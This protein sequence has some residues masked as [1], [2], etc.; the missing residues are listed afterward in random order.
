MK[1][2]QSRHAIVWPQT[3][4]RHRLERNQKPHPTLHALGCQS[5]AVNSP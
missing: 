2:G 5:E 4:L 3:V 1:D